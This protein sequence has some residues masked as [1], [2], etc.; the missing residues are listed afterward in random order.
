MKTFKTL[1]VILIV[2][3]S[4]A[5]VAETADM[6][7][8]KMLN[9][10]AK[11]ET[12]KNIKSQEQLWTITDA[13]NNIMKCRFLYKRPS[14][15]KMEITTA[16]GLPLITTVFVGSKGHHIVFGEK[17]DMLPDEINQ[18][19]IRIANWI[20]GLYNYNEKG[21]KL[22][23]LQ[24]KTIHKKI[25]NVI[26]STDKYGQKQVLYINAQTSFIEQI[27]GTQIDI[28]T[29]EK[30][31][32]TTGYESPQNFDGLNVAT[33]MLIY[34]NNKVFQTFKLEK[35]KNNASISDSEFT[36]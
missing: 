17:K 8:N 6:V 26:R 9:A 24:S 12:V 1:F 19:K 23:L 25:C 13:D 7:I 5:F 27:E 2:A 4:M 15:L 31:S 28:V 21:F 30:T 32:Y 35:L 11:P 29:R 36:K 3:I 22:E 10:Y 18:Y 34:N 14:N 20:E 16:D 33:T